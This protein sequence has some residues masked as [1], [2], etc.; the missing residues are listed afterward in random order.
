M[1]GNGA[2]AGNSRFRNNAPYVPGE[3]CTYV[4]VG[5]KVEM[6][7]LTNNTFRVTIPAFGVPP[8]VELSAGEY[9]PICRE[10]TRMCA[11]APHE[12]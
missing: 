4:Q 1:S 3:K 5:R 9:L 10:N 11:R 7:A 12:K 2:F 8:S 6:L